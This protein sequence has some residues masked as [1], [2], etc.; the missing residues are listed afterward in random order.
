V[1][2]PLIASLR[3]QLQHVA[4]AAPA[5]AAAARERYDVGPL[6]ALETPQKEFDYLLIDAA[7]PAA[8][9][10]EQGDGAESAGGI[11]VRVRWA[12]RGL[13]LSSP[14]RQTLRR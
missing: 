6:P 9:D 14:A 5:D 1:G 13:L 2:A 7:S 12:G 8:S 10:G 3:K 11:G 4:Q